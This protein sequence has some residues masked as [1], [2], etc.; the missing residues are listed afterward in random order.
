MWGPIINPFSVTVPTLGAIPNEQDRQS[1]DL[2]GRESYDLQTGWGAMHTL[3][4]KEACLEW[5]CKQCWTT[6]HLSTWLTH[7][8][9]LALSSVEEYKCCNAWITNI[10]SLQIAT[11]VMDKN[12]LQTRILL[13]MGRE[14]ILFLPGAV[15][16]LQINN[17]GMD[18][19]VSNFCRLI[20]N[21]KGKLFI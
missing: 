19:H 11:S 13:E 2:R 8:I 7:G 16:P 9:E 21:C 3:L 1:P 15:N 10:S 4:S 14:L 20:C 6:R 17:M 12:L 5:F 18:R